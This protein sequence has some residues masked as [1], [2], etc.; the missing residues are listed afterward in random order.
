MVKNFIRNLIYFGIPGFGATLLLSQHDRTV[1]AINK[2]FIALSATSDAH[3]NPQPGQIVSILLGSW[4]LIAILMAQRSEFLTFHPN[5]K[6][7][8]KSGSVIDPSEIKIKPFLPGLRAF[9]MNGMKLLIFRET[10]AK[11]NPPSTANGPNK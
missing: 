6:I 2:A 7:T 8:L 5:G 3:S 4:I 11:E 9:E 1:A 10:Y